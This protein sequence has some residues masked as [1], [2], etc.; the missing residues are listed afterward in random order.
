MAKSFHLQIMTAEGVLLEPLLY[1][2]GGM[3]FGTEQGK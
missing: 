3:R 2:L 1:R